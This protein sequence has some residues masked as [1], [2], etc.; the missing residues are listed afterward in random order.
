M[1][2]AQALAKK[3]DQEMNIFKLR[4]GKMKKVTKQWEFMEKKTYR[5]SV[6]KNHSK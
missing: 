4:Y 3:K 5:K 2:I 6:A 1:K